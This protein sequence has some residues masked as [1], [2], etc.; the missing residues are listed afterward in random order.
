MLI[1][2]F[3]CLATESYIEGQHFFKLIT[4]LS[5]L[6]SIVLST[7]SEN[8][9]SMHLVL[10]VRDVFFLLEVEL[11]GNERTSRTFS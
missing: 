8:F 3:V 9:I 6:K 2:L 11:F 7:L 5:S 10:V 1:L 4:N